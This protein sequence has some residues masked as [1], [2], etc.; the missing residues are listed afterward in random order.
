VASTIEEPPAELA[1]TIE[2]LRAELGG[3]ADE[4]LRDKVARIAVSWAGQGGVITVEWVRSMLAQLGEDEAAAI[5]RIFRTKMMF[6][7]RTYD[8]AEVIDWMGRNGV[9]RERYPKTIEEAVR[10]PGHPRGPRRPR[11]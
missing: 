5:K 2:E 10:G 1:S 9:K 4:E 7:A 8:P 3:I 6:A 11:R